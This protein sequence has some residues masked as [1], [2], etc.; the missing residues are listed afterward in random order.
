MNNKIFL[1]TGLLVLSLG[2][3]G[4]EKDEIQL[5]YANTIK[6]D[7]IRVHLNILASDSLEGRETGE[8]GLDMAADYISSQFKSFGIPAKNG[9]DY[10]QHYSLE[11]RKYEDVSIYEKNEN[12]LSTNHFKLLEDF[13][14]FGTFDNVT[15][16]SSKICFVGY[17]ISEDKYDDY[18]D[19]DV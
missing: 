8:K 4:Q 3:F 10:L 2:V 14:F 15:I 13:Y 11:N 9:S 1:I 6:S 19:I 12:V 5:K 7:D 17:G 16:K 18:K